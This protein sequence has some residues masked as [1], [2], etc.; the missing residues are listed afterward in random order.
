MLR[1]SRTLSSANAVPYVINLGGFRG[2]EQHNVFYTKWLR[3]GKDVPAGEPFKA[4]NLSWCTQN[5][6]A[7]RID[8][9]SRGAVGMTD[10]GS[11]RSPATWAP[12]RKAERLTGSDFPAGKRGPI[13]VAELFQRSSTG[14]VF[15]NPRIEN[16]FRQHDRSWQIEPLGPLGR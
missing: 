10:R 2:E 16:K 15:H 3:I 5:D 13:L 11:L 14:V 7:D 4:P 8:D 9:T 1:N 6:S 12:V